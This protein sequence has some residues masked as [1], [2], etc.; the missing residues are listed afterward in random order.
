M[1][2][3]RQKRMRQSRLRPLLLRP[4]FT[5]LA[6]SNA[7]RLVVIAVVATALLALVFDSP[8]GIVEAVPQVKPLQGLIVSSLRA[9]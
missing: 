4:L 1:A 6:R 3:D 9:L 2:N 8:S 7:A 5:N